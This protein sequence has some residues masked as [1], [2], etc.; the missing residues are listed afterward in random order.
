[1]RFSVIPGRVL[2]RIRDERGRLSLAHLRRMDDDKA[3]EYLLGLPGVGPKTA[4]CVLLFGMG[5]DVFPVDTHVHR[6]CRRLGL[7][8]DNATAEQTQEMMAGIVPSGRALSLHL[9][10]VRHGREVCRAQKPLCH[11]C[12]L[13]RLCPSRRPVTRTY[14]VRWLATALG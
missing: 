14:G 5:R 8:P 12:P 7:V 2:A 6:V 3:M 4:A 1:M 9:N 11:V 13:S 10:L